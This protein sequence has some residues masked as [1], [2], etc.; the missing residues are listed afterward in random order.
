MPPF[1]LFEDVEKLLFDFEET[2]KKHDV[3]IQPGSNLDTVCLAV[4][5]LLHKKNTP[6]LVDPKRDLRHYFAGILGVKTFMTKVVA[7]RDHVDSGCP[8]LAQAQLRTGRPEFALWR[9]R[10]GIS[11]A[12]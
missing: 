8:A 5:D 4:L 10:S 7:L 3:K 12:F 9:A 1:T 6:Q 2:L 11:E